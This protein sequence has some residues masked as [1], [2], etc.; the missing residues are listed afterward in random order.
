MVVKPIEKLVST[1]FLYCEMVL[2]FGRCEQMTG[3][4]S[5]HSP[6]AEAFNCMVPL[7]IRFPREAILPRAVE[8][9]FEELDVAEHV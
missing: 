2:T 8:A 5:S 7:R 1:C 6:R 3:M 4:W 9:Q